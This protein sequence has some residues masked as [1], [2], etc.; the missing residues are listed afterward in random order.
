LY[1]VLAA[2]RVGDIEE[3]LAATELFMKRQDA[4]HA[5]Q[6]CLHR[7]PDCERLLPKAAAVLAAVVEKVAAAEEAEE[8]AL[9]QQA[10]QAQQGG[11]GAATAGPATG[12]AGA[13]RWAISNPR[14]L[15]SSQQQQE[16]TAQVAQLAAI[17]DLSQV[18]SAP[19]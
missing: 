12:T 8:E 17:L 7:A 10:E 16:A 1:A 19:L 18:C 14:L 9:A 4:A 3:R 13:G 15:P 5:F 11:G 6:A 2:C